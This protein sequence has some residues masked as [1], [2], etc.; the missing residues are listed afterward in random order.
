MPYSIYKKLGGEE[1]KPTSISLQFADQNIKFPRRIVED[2]IIKIGKLYLLADFIILYMEKDKKMP[3]ILGKPFLASDRTLIDVQ[4]GKLAFRINDEI[5]TFNVFDLVKL[6]S[7]YE[8]VMSINLI[9]D[10]VDDCCRYK[11]V[12]SPLQRILMNPSDVVQEDEEIVQCFHHLKNNVQM[13]ESKEG[14]NSEGTRKDDF[15]LS[16]I[17]QSLR[18]WPEFDREVVDQ[19][20]VENVVVDHLSRIE[21]SKL[22]RKYEKAIVEEASIEKLIK[23]K[24]SISWYADIANYIV[25]KVMPSKLNANEATME[26]KEWHL[27]CYKVIYIGQAFSRIQ[28]ILYLNVMNAKRS[29]IFHE[30]K[31]CPSMGL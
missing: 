26:H 15:P 7:I 29:I 22:V 11:L 12:K 30:D 10:L 27:K 14:N 31:K 4:E 9:D 8:D 28:G 24:E 25:A 21:D 6:L 3:I 23:V 16:F 13:H 2:V 20:R 19:K 18:G 17:D 1:L 5:V